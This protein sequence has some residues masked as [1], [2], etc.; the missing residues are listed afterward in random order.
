ML[1]AAQLPPSAVAAAPAGHT[2][3]VLSASETYSVTASRGCVS[4][5]REFSESTSGPVPDDPLNA[6][7]PG[8]GREGWVCRHDGNV[9]FQGSQI[10]R[11]LQEAGIP[12]LERESFFWRDSGGVWHQDATREQASAIRRI[13]AGQAEQDREREERRV[14]ARDD[15]RQRNLMNGRYWTCGF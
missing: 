5:H 13:A 10:L 4:G 14:R 3:K 7:S 12:G 8:S 15:C 6:F 2:F 9:L 1:L 11:N